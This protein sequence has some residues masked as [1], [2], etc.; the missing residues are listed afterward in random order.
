MKNEK[1]KVRADQAAA[2]VARA[3]ISAEV[4][5]SVMPLSATRAWLQK[6]L[7]PT[8]SHSKSLNISPE[9]LSHSFVSGTQSV[10]SLSSSN[11]WTAGKFGCSCSISEILGLIESLCIDRCDCR[12]LVKQ[13]YCDCSAGLTLIRPSQM[14]SPNVTWSRNLVFYTRWSWH[15]CSQTQPCVLTFSK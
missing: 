1:T 15:H 5:N 6:I 13:F 8:G 14:L 3:W 9:I 4:F 10:L 11:T 7:V 2:P 12:C